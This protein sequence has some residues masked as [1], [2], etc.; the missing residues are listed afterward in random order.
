M[1]TTGMGTGIVLLIWIV[2]GTFLAAI[3]GLVLRGC[4]QSLT[5]GAKRG[6]AKAASA[7]ALFP[8]GLFFWAGFV[9]LLQAFVSQTLL[10]RDPGIGDTWHCPLPNGYSLLMVNVNDHGWVYNP[11][12]QPGDGVGGRSDAIGNVRTLQLAGRYILGAADSKASDDRF[13]NSADGEV[14]SFFLL[15][16]REGKHMTFVGYQPLAFQAKQLG[17]DPNLEPINSVYSRYRFSWFDVVAG[18]LFFVPPLAATWYLGRWILKVRR[19]RPLIA[20]PAV[21]HAA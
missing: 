17:I 19:T 21:T 4:T 16:T 3:G 14:D 12:T 7:A 6:R 8:F 13:Y 20:Q 9:F 15:D 1:G 18:L 2:A 5:R 10:Q 11:K